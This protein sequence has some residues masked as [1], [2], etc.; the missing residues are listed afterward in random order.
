MN[1][2]LVVLCTGLAL[3]IG[4]APATADFDPRT[5]TVRTDGA[6]HA[7]G[8]D[9]SPSGRPLVAWTDDGGTLDAARLSARYS[10]ADAI[11]GDGAFLIGGA[12]TAIHLDAAA[13]PRALAG[14]RVEVRLWVRPEGSDAYVHLYWYSGDPWPGLQG[15]RFT[16]A[17]VGELP[18]VPSG[19]ATDDGWYELTSGPVDF[20]FGGRLPPVILSIFDTQGDDHQ[21]GFEISGPT[22]PDR[23]A[24]VD[25]LEV[26]DLGPAAV[27]DAACRLPTAEETCGPHGVCLYGRCVDGAPIF[28]PLAPPAL[29]RALAERRAFELR[30]FDGARTVADRWPALEAGF[31]ALPAIAEA[32][33]FWTRLRA[34]YTDSGDGHALGPIP[35]FPAIASDLCAAP[36]LADRLPDRPELPLVYR[37]GDNAAAALEP[38]DAIRRIDGLSP[39]E[40]LAAAYPLTDVKGDPDA[41]ALQAGRNLLDLAL[42][43]GA[44]LEIARCADPDCAPE[45]IATLEVDLSDAHAALWDDAG[46]EPRR[47]TYCDYR[48]EDRGLIRDDTIDAADLDGVRLLTINGVPAGLPRWDATIVDALADGAELLIIDQ[49]LGVGGNVPSVALIVEA[50]IDAEHDAGYTMHP[51]FGAWDPDAARAAVDT[52]L[53]A[54]PDDELGWICGRGRARRFRGAD[55]T[56]PRRIAILGGDVISGNEYLARLLATRPGVRLFA[57]GPTVG[58]FGYIQDMPALVGEAT[59]GVLQLVDTLFDP[60]DP[61]FATGRGLPP[62]QRLVFRQSDLLA[63]RDTFIEAAL[64]WLHAEENP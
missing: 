1:R 63:D 61:A 5:G 30:T 36:G 51:P 29:R 22:D 33:R 13:W 47:T 14:R 21:P 49:R 24:R 40:W 35:V 62:D 15:R 54:N 46:A 60:G 11:E 48:L 42:L 50:L 56:T 7:E 39:E 4:A 3:V 52:C 25:A 31:A 19:R 45:A 20:A 64:D 32:H 26:I 8:F 38:G 43:T 28:G 9:Q 53:A 10:K 6:A 2:P 27:P 17:R 55:A 58:G 41:F 57:P 23:R 34:L 37:V 44:T 18:F 59:G 12:I 16:A